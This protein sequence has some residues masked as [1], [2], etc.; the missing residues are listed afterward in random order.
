MVGAQGRLGLLLQL[1]GEAGVEEAGRLLGQAVLQVVRL[2]PLSRHRQRVGHLRAAT[3]QFASGGG[4]S[5]G[6][7]PAQSLQHGQRSAVG[8]PA[9][10]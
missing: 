3:A 5:G 8:G 7:V 2:Q 10:S 9:G 6:G 4:K 1:S